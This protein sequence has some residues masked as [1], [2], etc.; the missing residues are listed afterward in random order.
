MRLSARAVEQYRATGPRYPWGALYGGQVVA[1]ALRAAGHTVPPGLHAH[2]VHA[3]YLQPGSDSEAI[4]LDVKC[5]RDGRSFSTR[6]V[7][8]RQSNGV[9]ATVLASFHIDEAGDTLPGV[10]AP[11]APEPSSLTPNSW[12]E[13]YDRRY[14]PGTEPGRALAWLRLA[15][16]LGDD[17]D[18]QACGLVFGA[19]D[20][21]DDAVR[22][23]VHPERSRDRPLMI[24]SLDYSV[25]FSR[26]TPS[27]GWRLHDYRCRGLAGACATVVGEVFDASGEHLAT[28]AQQMLVRR[29][30]AGHTCTQPTLATWP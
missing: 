18:L 15:D 25:R 17:P 19:D 6:A 3:Y 10:V 27:D 24:R 9:I 7:T 12:T 30:V 29:V 13:L 26:P 28:V 1:Q 22:A 4:D 16:R 14:A 5:V 23:L 21:F 2:S 8:A 11:S 20:I